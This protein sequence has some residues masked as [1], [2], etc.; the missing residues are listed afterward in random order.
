M[1][2]LFTTYLKSEGRAEKSIKAYTQD[3]KL[4][5]ERINK[6][7]E[8]IKYMD[9]LN[10]KNFLMENYSSST[11]HRALISVKLFFGFLYDIEVIEK[12]PAEK[13]TTNI[14]V[15]SKGQTSLSSEQVE[16]VLNVAKGRDKAILSVMFATGVRVSEMMNITLD[17][18]NN[19]ANGIQIVGKGN[20]KRKVF[21]NDAVC[22]VV[23][24]YL[25]TRKTGCE[26]LFTS[27]FGSKMTQESVSA[28]LKRVCKTA[29]IEGAEKISPH[30]TRHSFATN[31]IREGKNLTAVSKALGHYNASFTAKVYVDMDDSDV[32]DVMM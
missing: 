20:K 9:L 30:C 14:K 15:E 7:I 21:L 31:K 11:A 23:D 22:E 29:G 25:P 17:Q 18:Y 19:R 16:K 8:E 26:Y 28:M 13:L 12:N 4:M 3:V 32:C 1:L 10:Y 27:K 2:N 6:P 24:N 5:M